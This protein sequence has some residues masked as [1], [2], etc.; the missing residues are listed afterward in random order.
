MVTAEDAD[1]VL[2]MYFK[3]PTALEKH[4]LLQLVLGLPPESARARLVAKLASPDPM[5]RQ[6]AVKAIGNMP[7]ADRVLLIRPLRDDPDHGVRSSAKFLSQ[8][9]SGTLDPGHA[10]TPTTLHRFDS[11]AQGKIGLVASGLGWPY[12]PT[13]RSLEF[14]RVTG[15]RYPGGRHTLD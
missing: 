15:V 8:D 7:Y 2:D 6:A 11:P 10:T 9:R 3:R 14:V 4:E 13:P 1:W 12:G 5:N